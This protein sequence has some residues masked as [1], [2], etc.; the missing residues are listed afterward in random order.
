MTSPSD[1]ATGISS[2]TGAA[3]A[4]M[5]SILGILLLFLIGL[6]L[7]RYLVNICID[8]CILCDPQQA[9][10]T[11]ME[12]RDNMLSI[13]LRWRRKVSENTTTITT[14]TT[15]G[16]DGNHTTTTTTTDRGNV[17]N[18]NNDHDENTPPHPLDARLAELSIVERK[19]VLKHLIEN[20]V[21]VYS[22]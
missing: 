3:L 4:I 5:G 8:L 18:R 9:R 17:A 22:I 21:S 12:F 20:E 7:L 15:T 10:Q 2:T 19:V 14:T 11:T 13:C 1:P 6:F 16:D